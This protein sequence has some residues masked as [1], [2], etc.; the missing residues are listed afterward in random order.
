MSIRLMTEVWTKEIDGIEQL[1]LLVMADYAN[2]DGSSVFPSIATVAWKLGVHERTA[3]RHLKKLRDKGALVK[4]AD[5]R[6]H[7]PVEYRIDLSALADKPPLATPN[8]G[9]QS[10]TPAPNQGRQLAAPGVT[11]GASRGD[12]AA[13]PEPPVVEP[14]EEP[15]EGDPVDRLCAVWQK[16][17]GLSLIHI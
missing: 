16:I 9:R 1:A 5:A 2:D 12:A 6:Q 11:N 17:E 10:A 3:Q 13:P 4:V 7:H 15:T 14:P 8:Q